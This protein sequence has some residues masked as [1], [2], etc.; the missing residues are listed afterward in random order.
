M[1]RF[2]FLFC[3]SQ[4]V[5]LSLTLRPPAYSLVLHVN[6][7]GELGLSTFVLVRESESWLWPRH[8]SRGEC[9]DVKKSK[10]TKYARKWGQSYSDGTLITKIKHFGVARAVSLW[11]SR[12]LLW[13]HNHEMFRL[14]S[15]CSV[16]RTKCKVWRINR[17]V[18]FGSWNIGNPSS[19]RMLS[20]G[21]QN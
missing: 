21:V 18:L 8:G 19:W 13:F 15:R 4:L 2:P 20:F 3:C 14:K 9:T 6:T 17:D 5:L 10:G 16:R 7:T 12:S 1:G 11:F